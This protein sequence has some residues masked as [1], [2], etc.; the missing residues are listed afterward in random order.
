MGTLWFNLDSTAVR[1]GRVTMESGCYAAYNRLG[2][3]L[4]A[5]GTRSQAQDSVESWFVAGMLTAM[6][7][8]LVTR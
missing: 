8:L 7:G 1:I 2:H 6:F 5:Y 3:K 4:G